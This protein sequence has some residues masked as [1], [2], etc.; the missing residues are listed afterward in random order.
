[1]KAR[2]GRDGEHQL[3]AADLAESM[4]LAPSRLCF[5][6]LLL[7]THSEKRDAPRMRRPPRC[8]GGALGFE[9]PWSDVEGSAVSAL[10]AS[11]E[12]KQSTGVQAE[13]C[14]AVFCSGSGI[15]DNRLHHVLMMRMRSAVHASVW[16]CG[17]GA[18]CKPKAAVEPI[19]SLL[20]R[21]TSFVDWS[22]EAISLPLSLIGMRAVRRDGRRLDPENTGFIPVEN[23]TSLVEHHELQLDPSKLDM[24]LALVQ[25]NEE[26]QVCYQELIELVSGRFLHCACRF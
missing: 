14:A 25:S 26:G 10:G 21:E 9:W 1:M 20:P 23:F 11:S 2:C 7:R 15:R 16:T 24:L 4:E 22:Y 17:C 5:F 19:P 13:G 12:D 3:P 18:S 6:V 8:V